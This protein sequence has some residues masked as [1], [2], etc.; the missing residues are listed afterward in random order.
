MKTRAK[1]RARAGGKGK[2]Y[3]HRR[4]PGRESEGTR[5]RGPAR[6][7]R[8]KSTGPDSL[9][10]GAAVS[11]HITTRFGEPVEILG[12][13]LVRGVATCRVDGVAVRD[14]E[15]ARLVGDPETIFDAVA[16]AES[17]RGAA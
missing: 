4:T 16:D 1:G 17:A 9:P 15:I 8:R 2:S 5:G 7:D 13:C 12:G 6:A 10:G 11:S 14:I 3:I